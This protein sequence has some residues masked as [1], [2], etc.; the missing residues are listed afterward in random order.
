MKIKT[1]L[2]LKCLML[3]VLMTIGITSV[4]AGPKMVHTR[5]RCAMLMDYYHEGYCD[6]WWIWLTDHQIEI[7]YDIGTSLINSN[8][9]TFENE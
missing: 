3:S 8:C 1:E 4:Y 9:A 6:G 5:D 2:R 7:C